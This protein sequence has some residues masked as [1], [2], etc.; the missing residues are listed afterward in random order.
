L[1][2][3]TAK[4]A[5]PAPRSSPN[6]SRRRI[7]RDVSRASRHGPLPASLADRH[8]DA[9]HQVGALGPAPGKLHRWRTEASALFASHDLLVSGQARFPA[10][11]PVLGRQRIELEFWV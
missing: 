10:R 2:F 3:F 1:G 6:H 7:T 5:P 8:P 4:R 9:Q 11:G